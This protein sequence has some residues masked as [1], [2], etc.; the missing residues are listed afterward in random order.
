MD[1]IVARKRLACYGRRVKQECVLF[2]LAAAVT[3]TGPLRADPITPPAPIEQPAAEWPADHVLEHDLV[4]P[5]VLVIAKDGTVESASVEAGVGDPFDSIAVRT[6]LRWRF[7]PARGGAGPVS[8]RVRGV[9]RFVGVPKAAAAPAGPHPAPVA[10]AHAHPEP[11]THPQKLPHAHSRG[12][13]AAPP[14]EHAPPPEVLVRGEA[15][16]RSA[17]EVRRDRAVLTAAPHRTASDLMLTVPGVF[18]TQHSGE[19]KAHQI[20]FRGFDA[21]H[22]QDIEFWVAGAPVNE[23]SNVHGQGYADLHFVMPEVVRE[24]RALPGPYD[25]RQGDFAVAGT[26]DFD[27][28]YAE[29]G[30]TLKAGAG[31]FGRRRGFVAYHPEEAPEHTFAAADLEQSDGF[32]DGRAA[33]RASAIAQIEYPLGNGFVGRIMASNYAARFG[34][35]GVLRLDD[36]TAGRIDRFGSYDT[37]QGGRS[38]RTQVVASLRGG[39]HDTLFEL[40]PFLVRRSLILRSNYTGFLEDPISGDSTQQINDSTTFGGRA[41]FSKH[42]RLFSKQDAIEAGLSLRSDFVDQSQRRLSAVDSSVTETEVDAEVRAADIGA[43]LDAELHP[44]RRVAVRGG[45]RAD[46]LSFGVTDGGPQGGSA[47][48]SQGTHVGG[49]ATVDVGLFPGMSAVVSY[50]EGFRSPQARSLANGEKTPFTEVVSQELGLRYSEGKRVRA[51]L[52]GYRTT[53][54]DDLVFDEATAR[55]EPVPATLRL[56]IVADLVAEPEPWFTSAFGFTYTRATFSESGG[57]Y[58]EGELVPFVPQVVARGDLT[59]RPELGQLLHRK[60]TGRIGAGATYLYRRPIPFGELGTD[61]MLLDAVAG[62][63]LA[64]VE[65]TFEVWNLLDAEWNDG[66]FVYASNFQ[67]GAAGSQI[68][69]RHITAGAPRSL[70]LSLA[71]YI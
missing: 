35:A 36:V 39:E 70:M 68:P 59:A 28:G 67:R 38:Q 41:W 32:G 13:D 47:R 60:L 69:V 25:P 55:N 65:L 23:V 21:V 31:S 20:F 53:L 48:T 58:Q 6:A 44:V 62:A 40:A 12:H 15:R 16:A 71:L 64:E 45:V 27:L 52:A 22:G 3:W 24:V 46:G 66:E 8:A 18:V 10:P 26:M 4:I 37:E 61:V 63:R 49:K 29:P 9:V 2:A 7:E 5:V 50:G 57:R 42:F 11:H 34:S 43:Y 54:S 1:T 17:S 30:V 51:S 14:H 19:G 56:G 33:N